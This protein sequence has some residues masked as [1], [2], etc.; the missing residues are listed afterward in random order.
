MKDITKLIVT[1]LSGAAAS[2]IPFTLFYLSWSWAMTQVPAG[3]YAG[4]IKI[5]VSLAMLLVGGG[6]TLWCAIVGGLIVTTFVLA[7]VS[8]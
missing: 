7:L 5:G 4:L 6:I 1:I 2:A 8:D 3:D